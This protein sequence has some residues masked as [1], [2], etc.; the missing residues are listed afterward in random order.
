MARATLYF[1]L[2]YPGLIGDSERELTA[3]RLPMI[4]DWHEEDP[5][6]DYERHRNFVI[7]E[8]PGNRNPLID[9]PE[10]ARTIDFAAT[11]RAAL[12]AVGLHRL[13]AVI[14]SASSSLAD[15]IGPTRT[16]APAE[17]ASHEHM[18]A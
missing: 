5:V 14:A 17:I 10:W 12:P 2:R 15:W 11:A 1:L 16:E 13:A 18:F 7:A 8:R 3:D 6:S 4:L 9:H